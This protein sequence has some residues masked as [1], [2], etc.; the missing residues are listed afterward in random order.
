LNHDAEVD[1]LDFAILLARWRFDPLPEA[2]PQPDSDPMTWGAD[3]NRVFMT[4]AQ[5]PSL[6]H[7]CASSAFM[8][9][10]TFYATDGTS[11]EYLFR[12]MDNIHINSG[13]MSFLVGQP[14]QWR[15][16]G[17]LPG[18]DGLPRQYRFEV[19]ARN[20]GNWL[21][22]EWSDWGA[23]YPISSNLTPA[24]A[25]WE[26]EPNLVAGVISMKAREVTDSCGLA[27]EYFFTCSS[28]ALSSPVWQASP[29]YNVNV[30]Q[31]AH[32]LY[33]F[34]VQARNME[35]TSNVASSP[36]VWVDLTCKLSPTKTEWESV[37]HGHATGPSGTISMKAREV[38][39]SCGTVVKY[40]F[41]CEEA[42]FLSSQTWQ[43]S[44]EYSVQDVP[45]G[46]Y[47]FSAQAMNAEGLTNDPSP[48]VTA[49]LIPPRPSPM[50]WAW[51]GTPQA[52]NLGGGSFDWWYQMLA[53]EALDNELGSQVEYLFQC[54]D[55]S[56]FNSAWQ[57]ARFY[58]ILI[59]RYQDWTW[60]VKARD[61]HGNETAW[62]NLPYE[63]Q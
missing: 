50:K 29:E 27:V 51:G 19:K 48:V 9:A 42:P 13:W 18:K 24:Y 31:A 53:S 41:T 58:T 10:D 3:P 15:V 63:R 11:V 25:Q 7:V 37:P 40:W 30:T 32:R 47:S 57:S 62:S 21:E 5:E 54:N 43:E 56:R 17:L 39:D 55:D 1:L 16:T 22:A 4:W 49:D 26:A 46:E 6:P 8:V 23:V 44:R 35:G 34:T 12:D 36:P 52:I 59:G 28:P 61:Q 45:M 2:P 60:S 33:S 14:P 38:L 20:R